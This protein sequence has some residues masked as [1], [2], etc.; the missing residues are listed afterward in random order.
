M[1]PRVRDRNGF[2]VG[3]YVRSSHRPAYWGRIVW[4]D[5]TQSGEIAVVHGSTNG[6]TESVKTLQYAVLDQLAAEAGE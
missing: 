4:F 5:P 2:K 1:P 3:D 6:F